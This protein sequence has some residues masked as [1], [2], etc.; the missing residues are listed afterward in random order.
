MVK[1]LKA[2]RDHYEAMKQLDDAK[3]AAAEV[4]RA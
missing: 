3:K 4:S 1:P 2:A